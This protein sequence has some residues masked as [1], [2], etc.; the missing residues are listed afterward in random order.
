MIS[1][2]SFKGD[3]WEEKTNVK[4]QTEGKMKIIIVGLSL[5]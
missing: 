1:S 3:G 4:V 2:G 5:S